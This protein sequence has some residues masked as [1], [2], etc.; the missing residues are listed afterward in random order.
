M[1][2]AIQVRVFPLCMCNAIQVRV[3]PCVCAIQVRVFTLCMCN[4]IQV[5]V[6]PLCMCNAIQVMVLQKEV[7]IFNNILLGNHYYSWVHYMWWCHLQFPPVCK[8]DF[9]FFKR[10]ICLGE[11]YELKSNMSCGSC[12]RLLWLKCPGLYTTK[13]FTPNTA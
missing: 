4:A 5:R 3:F 8:S 2:N 12:L 10:E 13:L 1:C 7:I 11:H 6:F 9:I